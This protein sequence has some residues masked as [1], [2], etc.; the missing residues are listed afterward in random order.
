M[1]SNHKSSSGLAEKCNMHSLATA[2]EEKFYL[3][4]PEVQE[5]SSGVAD[6]VS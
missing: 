4:S 5:W 2:I 1:L 3:Q 6:V